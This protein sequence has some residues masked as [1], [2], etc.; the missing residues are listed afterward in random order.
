MVSMPARQ[1]SQ[2]PQAEYSHGTPTVSPILR[3]ADT[4]AQGGD[5]ACHLM[6]WNQGKIGQGRPIALDGVKIAMADPAGPDLDQAHR[7]APA[8]GTGTSSMMSG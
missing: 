7:R 6:A 2:V 1:N 8:R 3:L 4:V 5:M